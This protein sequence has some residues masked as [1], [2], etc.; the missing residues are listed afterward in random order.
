MDC[1]KNNVFKR[2]MNGEGIVLPLFYRLK[3]KGVVYDNIPYYYRRSLITQLL[4]SLRK[5]ICQNVAPNCVF[6]ATR[7][8]MYRLCGFKIGGG[9]TTIGMKCYFDDL[10]VKEMLAEEDVTISYGVYFASHGKHQSHHKITIRKG[11]YIGT[12]AT[13]I[14]T[15]DIEIGENAI[16]GA[17]TL[18]NRSIPPNSTAVGVPCRI[19]KHNNDTE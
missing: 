1:H 4:H 11:A 8:V 10:C 2:L 3:H 5:F 16:V 6:N 9:K 19:I 13:I 18:V 7:M 15:E 12:R 14:A 17:M